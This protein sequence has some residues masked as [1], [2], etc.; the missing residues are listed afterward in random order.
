L[1]KYWVQI[2]ESSPFVLIGYDGYKLRSKDTKR[3]MTLYHIGYVE[4]GSI[5][6]LPGTIGVIGCDQIV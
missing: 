4:V 6:V 5:L 1:F 3:G 2:K